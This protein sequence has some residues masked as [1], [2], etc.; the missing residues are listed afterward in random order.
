MHRQRPRVSHSK[1][2]TDTLALT[3]DPTLTAGYRTRH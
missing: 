3:L 2:L 1:L